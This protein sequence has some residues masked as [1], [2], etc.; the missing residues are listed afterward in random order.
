MVE[1][2]MSVT[3]FDNG[4]FLVSSRS[5]PEMLHL[6]DVQWQETPREK[7]TVKCGCESSLIHGRI[8]PHILATVDHLK[9]LMGL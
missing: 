9:K 6:V 8:C 1:A 3:P 7:I 5:R 4:T 2:V